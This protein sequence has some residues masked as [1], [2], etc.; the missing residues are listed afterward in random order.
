MQAVIAYILIKMAG[1]RRFN[2]SVHLAKGDRLVCAR[3]LPVGDNAIVAVLFGSVSSLCFST[4]EYEN[5][6]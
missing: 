1:E 3:A 2:L 6:S 4:Q 5:L